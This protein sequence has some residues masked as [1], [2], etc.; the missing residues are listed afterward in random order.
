MFESRALVTTLS[1]HQGRTDVRSGTMILLRLV[2]L[3]ISEC[4]IIAVIFSHEKTFL[5]A[6]PADDTVYPW[7]YVD[8]PGIAQSGASDPDVPGHSGADRAAKP[9]SLS[10]S[11][12]M[13]S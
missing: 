3:S 5:T 13:R 11:L 9:G 7:V 1:T 12:L 6:E 4:A 10:V 8:S 2:P